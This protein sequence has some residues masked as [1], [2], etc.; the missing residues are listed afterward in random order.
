M[1]TVRRLPVLFVLVIS[2]I[3]RGESLDAARVALDAGAPGEAVAILS[4]VEKAGK[5]EE[6]DELLYLLAETARLYGHY[7]EAGNQLHRIKDPVWAAMGYYNLAMSHLVEE[8]FR[9]VRSALEVTRALAGSS[10][11]PVAAEMGDRARITEGLL[12]LRGGNIRS[13]RNAF[14]HVRTDSTLVP[15]GLYLL[16]LAKARAG[17]VHR[18]L[19]TWRRLRSFP[20]AYPGVIESRIASVWAHRLEG[21]PGQALS[22]TEANRRFLEKA[23]AELEAYRD[24]VARNGAAEV[25]GSRLAEDQKLIEFLRS[26]RS[27][28]RTSS[29]AWF[30]RFLE[31]GGSI[32]DAGDAMDKAFLAFLDS[33]EQ[34]LRRFRDR[35]LQQ[36]AEVIESVALRQADKRPVQRGGWE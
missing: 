8:S 34:L 9:R 21:R 30:F 12:A 17:E 32:K 11:D 16:G 31:R 13:A 35:T 27:L 2:V 19:Q 15:R 14:E 5:V 25:V 23:I 26:G 24:R 1:T 36:Q 22:I 3:A 20:V 33:E 7:S 10:S 18:A 6:R 28:S 4:D 29:V